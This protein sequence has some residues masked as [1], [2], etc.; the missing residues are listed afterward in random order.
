MQKYF[1]KINSLSKYA[2]HKIF[3]SFAYVQKLLLNDNQAYE[4]YM[5]KMKSLITMQKLFKN[6]SLKFYS[7]TDL[8]VLLVSA[9]R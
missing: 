5:N 3:Q 6:N 7:D 2:D 9:V 4:L 8:G 1:H